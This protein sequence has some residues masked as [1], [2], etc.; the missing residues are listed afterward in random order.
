MK[1]INDIIVGGLAGVIS[2]SLVVWV[3]SN[4]KMNWTAVACMISILVLI[5]TVNENRSRFKED[6]IARVNVSDADKLIE[7]V[8]Q[9][10]GNYQQY[11]RFTIE[12]IMRSAGI[13]NSGNNDYEIQEKKHLRDGVLFELDSITS[14]IK[15]LEIRITKDVSNDGLFEKI[16]SIKTE[17]KDFYLP[18]LKLI[19]DLKLVDGWS[20]DDNEFKDKIRSECRQQDQITRENIEIIQKKSA[21]IYREL[22][23]VK[24]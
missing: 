7:L 22:V 10:I 6:W 19:D 1:R 11:Q 21:E 15:L 3:N 5:V 24:Q 2:G 12:I 23:T 8:S 4:H 9:Y 13:F 20:S 18:N 17:M 14:Q 16:E